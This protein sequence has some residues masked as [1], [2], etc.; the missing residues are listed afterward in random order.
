MRQ[1]YLNSVMPQPD[2]F[3]V[4]VRSVPPPESED[5]SYSDN[6]DYFFRRFHPMEYLSHQMVYRSSLIQSLRVGSLTLAHFH[7]GRMKFKGFFPQLL[8]HLGFL[9]G[10][11]STPSTLL[12]S[13]Q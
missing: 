12:F 1:E 2:Q 5:Q 13:I 3:S 7:S 6:V 10:W 9:M 4:L 11:V 8:Q